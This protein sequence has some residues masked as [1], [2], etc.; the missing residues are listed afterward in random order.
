MLFFLSCLGHASVDYEPAFFRN[1]T[2]EEAVNPWSKSP[3][4]ME[5]DNISSRY[6]VLALKLKSVL[7]PCKDRNDNNQDNSLGLGADFFQVM[8][9]ILIV[10][11]SDD[12]QDPAEDEQQFGR[13]KDWINSY[14]LHKIEVTDVLSHFSDISVKFNYEFDTVKEENDGQQYPKG[15]QSPH[16][17]GEEYMYMKVRPLPTI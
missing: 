9:V 6:F 13:L 8:T 15:N 7:D 12:I 4:K 17:K 5:A 11:F 14:H 16:R 2:E 1:C 10:S 3:L